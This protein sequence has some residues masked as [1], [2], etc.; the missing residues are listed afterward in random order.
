MEK[1]A[2]SEPPITTTHQL[3]GSYLMMKCVGGVCVVGLGWMVWVGF[4][5]SGVWVLTHLRTTR[6]FHNPPNQTNRGKDTDPKEHAQQFYSAFSTLSASL[7]F[8]VACLPLPSAPRVP[9]LALS[10]TLTQPPPPPPLSPPL[11]PPRR[12]R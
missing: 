10:L 11:F 8:C 3:L 4:G 7:C 2:T 5:L 6:R 12:A 9:E 1:L